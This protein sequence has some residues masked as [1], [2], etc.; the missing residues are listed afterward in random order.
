MS[1]RRNL[2]APDRGILCVPQVSALQ[3]YLW[4]KLWEQWMAK[5]P[6]LLAEKSSSN[7][8]FKM[9]LSFNV[10][11]CPLRQ[12]FCPD[13]FSGVILGLDIWYFTSLHVKTDPKLLKVLGYLISIL[14]YWFLMSVMGSKI[15]FILC[16]RKTTENPVCLP[17]GL[18]I[19]IR[20]V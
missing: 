2:C 12:E 17:W 18:F 5:N 4:T 1:D 13:S 16:H 20:W 19:S 8:I 3:V 6:N 15:D 7:L 9:L 14:F 11:F 10:F